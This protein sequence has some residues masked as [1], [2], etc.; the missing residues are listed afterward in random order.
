MRSNDFLWG[1]T[2]INMFNNMFMLEY[3]AGIL[4]YEIG[5]YYH[6]TNNLHYYE[7][8]REKIVS[9]SKVVSCSN[10]SYVYKSK[11]ESL[12]SFDQ[13]LKKLE[14]WEK[15]IRMRESEEFFES[16][17][18]FL[19]DWAL[20]LYSKTHKQNGIKFHNPSLN[21]LFLKGGY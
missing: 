13:Q 6:I 7:E 20:A 12:T 5:S 17:N 14:E 16:E 18:D 1:A 4:G 9:L 19:H 21:S 15:S 2:G 11:F 8:F 10:E 3:F